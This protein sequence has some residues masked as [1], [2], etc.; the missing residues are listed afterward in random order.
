MPSPTHLLDTSVYSQPLRKEPLS[1][2]VSKWADLGEERLAVSVICE[3]EVLQGL[4]ELGS[5]RLWK[6]YEEVLAGRL[7]VLPVD[8][9]VAR[10]YAEFSAECR[11]AGR[12][13][14]PLDLIIAATAKTQRLTLATCNLKHFT[15]LAGLA[16]EDWS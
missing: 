12:S 10:N 7:P 15:G 14:P 1:H 5:D 8:E 11:K 3:A 16:V 6:L 2:V 9:A 4:I 13:K